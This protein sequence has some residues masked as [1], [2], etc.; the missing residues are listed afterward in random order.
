MGAG[1]GEGGAQMG[2]ALLSGLGVVVFGGWVSV[3]VP[4]VGLVG[5]P[6]LAVG[7][8]ARAAVGAVGAPMVGACR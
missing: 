5:V 8:C 1:M 7:W 4:A 3:G 2:L 6:L